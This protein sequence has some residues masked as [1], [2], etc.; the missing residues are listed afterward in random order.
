MLR[1][2]VNIYAKFFSSGCLFL[3]RKHILDTEN[4]VPQGLIPD[5]IEE[6]VFKNFERVDD[7]LNKIE[8][9]GVVISIYDFSSGF[10]L[11]IYLNNMDAAELKIDRAF[12]ACLD[13]NLTHKNIAES[14]IIRVKNIK[15]L[16]VCEGAKTWMSKIY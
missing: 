1:L 13:K 15:I 16:P 11:L 2:S 12:I 8:N 3:F 10:S 4:V 9:L 5:I 14:I 6:T 7:N